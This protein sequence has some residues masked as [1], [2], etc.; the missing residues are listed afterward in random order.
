MFD[1]SNDFIGIFVSIIFND[2]WNNINRKCK[3]FLRRKVSSKGSIREYRCTNYECNEN[4]I[5]DFSCSNSMRIIIIFDTLF[6][7]IQNKL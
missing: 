2:N 3:F 5:M 1:N 6:S 7:K 4:E